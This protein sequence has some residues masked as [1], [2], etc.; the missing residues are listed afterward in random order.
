MLSEFDKSKTTGH[1]QSMPR[2]SVRPQIVDSALEQFHTR[3]FHN[4]SVEDITKAAGVPKGSFYN[5][6]PSKDAL[7]V[8]VL[9][10]Y[11][12][13]SVWRASDDSELPPLVRLRQRF[14]AMRD[15]LV[16]REYTR[17]CL[18]A[19]MGSELAD[20]NEDVRA[21]VEASL[22]YRSDVATEML[23][24]AQQA[25]ELAQ[26]HDAAILGPFLVNAWEGVVTR[27]KVSKSSE[28]LDGFFALFDQ[29]L[30]R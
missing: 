22:K 5:H 19:N 17:G 3:G 16:G 10:Q 21:E 20:L 2:I 25:G 11:A 1:I 8:E 26:S 7:A 24:D 13:R 14:E 15:T 27:A 23:H 9:R 29:I 12:S 28:A 18:F 6:F 4:C 30:T